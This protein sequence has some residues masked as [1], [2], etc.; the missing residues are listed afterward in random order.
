MG[1]DKRCRRPRQ[2]RY[3]FSLNISLRSDDR[4]QKICSSSVQRHEEANFF[5]IISVVNS[6]SVAY[7]LRPVE[8]LYAGPATAFTT[9]FESSV[10]TRKE[11]KNSKVVILSTKSRQDVFPVFLSRCWCKQHLRER[12]NGRSATS[13]STTD[14][15]ENVFIAV[16]LC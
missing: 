8:C 10:V 7:W 3:S 15:V 11:D 5:S 4:W 1:L 6:V 12:L 2:N 14:C 9:V 13:S 16:W